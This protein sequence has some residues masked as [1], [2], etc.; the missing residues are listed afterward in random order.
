MAITTSDG[1]AFFEYWSKLFKED[2]ERF[3]RERKA[4]IEEAITEAPLH[5]Q[6]QLRALQ[7]EIDEQRGKEDFP[8]MSVLRL[9]HRMWESYL[10]LLEA[11]SFLDPSAAAQLR[12]LHDHFCRL[13]DSLRKRPAPS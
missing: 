8:H 2:P 13:R 5:R 12:S 1:S 7:A 11:W 6:P 4:V 3:E 9:H 10:K